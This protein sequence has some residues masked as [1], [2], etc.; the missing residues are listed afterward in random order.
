[1]SE[2]VNLA[3]EIERQ[4]PCEII[5]FMKKAGELAHQRGQRLC[6]IG[7]AVRDLLL[8]IPTVD[9]DLIVEGDAIKLAWGLGD[10][11]QG[12]V[13]VHPHFG[14]ATV[15]WN[16]WSI[17]MVTARSETYASPG[18]LPS[19]KPGSITDDLSRRDF[20]INT[21]AVEL[22]AERY[23]ELVDVYHGRQDLENR[24]IRILHEKSFIDDATRIWRALRYEQR[25]DFKLEEET[26]H[27]LKRDIKWL[28][29]ISG[30][31][32]RHELELV[33]KEAFPEKSLLRAGELGV[34]AKLHPSLKGDEWLAEKYNLARQ[35]I[36]PDT[37]SRGLYLAL[38]AYRLEDEE[39]ESF[40]A[41]LRL[42]KADARIITETAAIKGN[43]VELAVEGISPSRIYSLLH[44]NLYMAALANLLAADS[45]TVRGR[46]KL[47]LDKFRH[48]KPLL[49]G[50][51]IVRMGVAPG[52]R[53]S[54]ILKRIRE[55]KLDGKVPPP[56]PYPPAW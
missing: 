44:G 5:G 48:V 3:S 53:I 31:R 35:A 54:E 46:I 26:L 8:K 43:L 13:I 49:K 4:F 38:L 41:R 34:L 28:D 39:A 45:D 14:T 11:F 55:A 2:M 37:S 56:A 52:P 21:M 10:I 18:A 22:N 1:M 17:D 30:D 36:L 23:G 50:D 15:K 16:G 27:F 47:Y 25:L 20:T 42:R 32:L 12:R 7:G 24:L 9:I 51:D 6:L 29:A 33:L 40:I 19:V